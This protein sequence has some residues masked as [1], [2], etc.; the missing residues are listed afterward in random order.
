VFNPRVM[1]HSLFRLF[2]HLPVKSSP[3]KKSV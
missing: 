2:L 3:F 1:R